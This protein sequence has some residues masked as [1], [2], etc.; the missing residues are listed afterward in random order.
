LNRLDQ[1]ISKIDPTLGAN[2]AKRRSKILH[3]IS[4][5]RNKFHRVQIERDEIVNRQLRSLFASL[6]PGGGLQERTLN[7]ETFASRPERRG[8]EGGGFEH[9]SHHTLAHKT[10]ATITVSLPAVYPRCRRTGG[11]TDARQTGHAER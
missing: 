10:Q 7:V 1:E 11:G 4:A 2:L 9:R 3:H 5:V 8:G 6:L